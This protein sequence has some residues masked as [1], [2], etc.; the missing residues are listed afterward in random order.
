MNHT[1]NYNLPQWEDTD[2]VRREDVNAAM[3]AIDA[4]LAKC[5]DA[6]VVSG[7]YL[8]QGINPT[9]TF[10]HT[11][12]VVIIR[13]PNNRCPALVLMQGCPTAYGTASDM[14]NM[15]N[16]T[17]RGKSVTW[18]CADGSEYGY[19]IYGQTYSYAALL[20]GD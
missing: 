6:F 3:S 2:A 18:S 16:V 19:Y 11:P 1:T 20:L 13:D 5:G 17:W 4:A 10:E 12:A 7:S 15:V 8:G 9:L 14:F